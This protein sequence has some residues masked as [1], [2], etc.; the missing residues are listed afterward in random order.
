M[1][2]SNLIQNRPYLPPTQRGKLNCPYI[3]RLAPFETGFE[4]EW[5][6]N[7]CTG[8]HMLYYG[9]RGEAKKFCQPVTDTV[10]RV[11]GLMADSEYEFYLEAENGLRSNTRLVKYRREVR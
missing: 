11:E 1:K 8:A 6:D 10:V 5:L 3:C 2:G 4:L 7:H 9:I